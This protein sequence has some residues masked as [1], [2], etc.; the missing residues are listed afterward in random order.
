M[1][2]ARL[3]SA[4]TQPWLLMPLVFLLRW[5]RAGTKALVGRS[6]GRHGSS[7][8]GGAL[9]LVGGITLAAGGGA[10]PL[11]TL[12]GGLGLAVLFVAARS[13]VVVQDVQTA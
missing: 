8:V 3:P 11:L 10:P 6:A 4:P 5:G 1:R 9:V 12:G 13:W 2:N 7:D